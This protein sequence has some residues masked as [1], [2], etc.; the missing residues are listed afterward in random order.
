MYRY[1]LAVLLFICSVSSSAKDLNDDG[2]T[3]GG[4]YYQLAGDNGALILKASELLFAK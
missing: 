2:L 1:V 4:T 3:S